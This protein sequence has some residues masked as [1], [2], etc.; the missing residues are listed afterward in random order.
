MPRSGPGRK[1]RSRR[2]RL[3]AEAGV[4]SSSEQ[5]PC[6][7]SSPSPPY[8]L[9]ALLLD[10]PRISYYSLSISNAGRRT[11][12][13][14]RGRTSPLNNTSYPLLCPRK[15][16]TR[17]AFLCARRPADRFAIRSLGA[18]SR[19][20]TEVGNIGL[21]GQQVFGQRNLRL[22]RMSF[23]VC[24]E[25]LPFPRTLRIRQC[26]QRLDTGYGLPSNL[27]HFLATG[28]FNCAEGYEARTRRRRTSQAAFRK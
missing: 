19:P 20:G 16:L 23:H 21:E 7:I 18:W 3:P 11:Q 24:P 25:L 10:D 2:H 15:P 14:G 17:G 12:C 4:F 6:G 22:P 26:H 9:A 27:G 13:P 5:G 1:L 28:S 8:W